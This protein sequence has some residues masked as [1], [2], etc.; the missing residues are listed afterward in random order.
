[1]YHR[2]LVDACTYERWLV[3][4]IPFDVCTYERWLVWKILVGVC[5]YE[6]WLVHDGDDGCS[7]GCI[8]S[9]LDLKVH[10]AW[11]GMV[12]HGVG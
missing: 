7:M 2:L 3:W 4:Q 12:W 1:V 8:C 9:K 5:T 10:L 11:G 6:R